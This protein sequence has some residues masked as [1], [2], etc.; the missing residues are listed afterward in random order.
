M[1]VSSTLQQPALSTDEFEQ[2]EVAEKKR[3]KNKPL[4]FYIELAK[5]IEGNL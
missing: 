1:A 4:I 5:M 3:K 2:D